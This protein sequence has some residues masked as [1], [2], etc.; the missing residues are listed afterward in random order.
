MFPYTYSKHKDYGISEL[1][2]KFSKVN[3]EEK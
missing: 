1:Q 3:A 2:L